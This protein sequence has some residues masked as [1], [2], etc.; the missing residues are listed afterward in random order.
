MNVYYIMCYITVICNLTLGFSLIFILDILKNNNLMFH[1]LLLYLLITNCKQ[2]N[3]KEIIHKMY[4]FNS[5]LYCF[6]CSMEKLKINR[7]NKNIN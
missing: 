5:L 4:I 3:T 7:F 6:K 2:C 1:Y